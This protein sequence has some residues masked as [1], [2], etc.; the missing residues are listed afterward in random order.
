MFHRIVQKYL[1]PRVSLKIIVNILCGFLF[2]NTKILAQS[3]RTDPIYDPEI[4]RLGIAPLLIRHFFKRYVEHLR[5]RDPVDVLF[6]LI[7]VDQM[8]VPGTMGKHS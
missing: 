5:R 2:G 7:R 6:F 8:S 4:H 1:D 3:K